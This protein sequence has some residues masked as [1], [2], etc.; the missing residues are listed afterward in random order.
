MVRKVLVHLEHADPVLAAEDLLQLVVGKDF[1][2]VL[3]ILQV[4][5]ANVVPD[6]RHDLA[7][8]KRR[9]SG[10]RREIRRRLNRA[11]QSAPCFTTAFCHHGPPVVPPVIE[12][13]A[14]CI[15]M[16]LQR[17]IQRFPPGN[18]T[19]L[20]WAAWTMSAG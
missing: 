18:G 11:G 20:V 15:A 16:L 10:D 19:T 3:R 1:P 13:K 9:A 7:A 12:R 2:L 17:E 5:L 14:G 4:V 8:R 6:L